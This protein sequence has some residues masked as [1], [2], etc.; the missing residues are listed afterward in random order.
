MA[1]YSDLRWVMITYDELWWLMV[2]CGDVPQCTLNF[3]GKLRK[4]S[5]GVNFSL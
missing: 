1:I 3:I 4:E 5:T 2:A